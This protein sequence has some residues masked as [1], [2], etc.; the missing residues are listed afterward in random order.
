[1]QNVIGFVLANLNRQQRLHG[2]VSV[3]RNVQVSIRLQSKV[4]YNRG[5]FQIIFFL[6]TVSNRGLSGR[7]A[8]RYHLQHICQF[9][10]MAQDTV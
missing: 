5:N 4:H 2:L 1:M 7:A 9:A 6:E 10:R 3:C 8:K